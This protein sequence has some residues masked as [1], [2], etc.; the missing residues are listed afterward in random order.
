MTKIKDV[1]SIVKRGVKPIKAKDHSADSTMILTGEVIKELQVYKTHPIRKWKRHLS[2]KDFEG[3]SRNDKICL[4]YWVYPFKM[5]EKAFTRFCGVN[6]MSMYLFKIRN[7]ELIIKL[8]PIRNA[9]IQ[10]EGWS[11]L[12]RT[13]LAI[14]EG[15]N[16][17]QNYKHAKMLFEMLDWLGKRPTVNVNIGQAKRVRII[18]EEYEQPED[19]RNIIDVT[20]KEEK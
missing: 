1:K 10:A 15:K 11:A 8:E 12:Q 13:L 4:L 18:H 7:P 2:R 3:L 16:T 6:L 19:E 9:M 5:S 17:Q 20:P 14:E